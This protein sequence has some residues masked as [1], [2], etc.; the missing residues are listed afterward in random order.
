LLTVPSPAV[1]S[2][3][4]LVASAACAGSGTGPDP[5]PG[6]REPPASTLR[7]VTHPTLTVSLLPVAAETGGGGDAVV[8]ADSSGPR[9]LHLL[10]D[11]GDGARAAD[12]LREAGID[13]LDLLVLTHA[14]FD[15]YGGM[16]EV[17]DAAHVRAFA[18]NGQLRSEADYQAVQ[19]R[20]GAEADT[21]FVVTTVITWKDGSG[22]GAEVTLLPPYAT[23]LG[24]DT[25]DGAEL[26]EGSL[27]I[28]VRQGS[29]TFLS[30]GDAEARANSRF[31]STYPALVDVEAM[32]VGHHGSAD[33]TQSFWLDATSPRV[34]VVSANGTTHPHGSVLELLER[35]GAE[36]F[37]T[38][39]HGLVTFRVEAGGAYAVTT[40]KDARLRCGAGSQA[41]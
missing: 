17:L 27:G 30:T 14:H 26:N 32:K 7:T 25:D 39:Q 1:V 10:L 5:D 2:F 16:D 31:A 22:G 19:A 36:L 13:T 38:P 6:L 21:S 34:A 18:H 4:L 35:R 37:C 29:F 15:H 23:F 11:A 9:L 8:V 33:A 20:A 41:Y 24:N 12:F 40:Q 28:R 3:L